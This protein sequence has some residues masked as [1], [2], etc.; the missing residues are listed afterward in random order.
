M[1]KTKILVVE[2]ED[3]V[4]MNIKN[5]LKDLGYTVVANVPSGEKVIQSVE[6]AHPDLALMDIK[7]KGDMDGV[8]ATEQICSRFNIPVIYL[9]A[10]R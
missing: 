9:T 3:I 8:Q 7:L 10:C 4:A 5:R 6:E 2:D 1:A